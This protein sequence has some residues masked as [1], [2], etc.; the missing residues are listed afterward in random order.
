MIMSPFFSICIPV[1]KNF[2]Y[3]ERLLHSVFEQT[4]TD[5]EIVITDD[6]PGNTIEV[7]LNGHYSDQRISYFRNPVPLGTP[8]NWNEA[9][10]RS[11]GE[12]IKLMHDDDWFAHEHALHRLHDAIISTDAKFVYCDY[13]NILLN[14]NRSEV[15]RIKGSFIRNWWVKKNPETLYAKNIV[16]PPSVVCVHRSINELYDRQMKWLVD[17]DYYI[18][19]LNKQSAYYIKDKLINIGIGSEQVTRYT[20]N[21]PEVEI[22][23][24]LRLASKINHD[25]L[26]NIYFYDAWWRLLRNLNIRDNTQ[27]LAHVG[28]ENV[29][30]QI[31]QMMNDLKKLPQWLLKMG[32]LSKLFMTFSYFMYKLKIS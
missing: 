20:Q 9:I 21:R 11:K 7:W 2:T 5:F 12:W 1:Y 10:R 22:P 23:E 24:G 18:R 31:F 19:I 27:L 28:G 14:G 8:E 15:P 16:G 32:L 13:R 17:V 29:P 3:L 4:F 25:P 30:K 6:S 26:L